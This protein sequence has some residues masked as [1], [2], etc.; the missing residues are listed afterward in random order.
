MTD[1]DP[2]SQPRKPKAFSVEDTPSDT[3]AGQTGRQ[4]GTADKQRKPAA[5]PVT[6]S[7]TMEQ[8]DPFASAPAELEAITPP[9]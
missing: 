4:A 9:A 6:A 8:E 2:E 3:R 7:I 1:R 5:I